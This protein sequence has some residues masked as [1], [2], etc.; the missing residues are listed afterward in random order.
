MLLPVDMTK[1]LILSLYQ[2]PQTIF[3]LK[4]ISLLVPQI[5]YQNLKRRLYYFVKSGKLIRVR[6]G[7]YAKEGY[8]VR[9][10]ANKLYAPSYVSFETVLQEAGLIFQ[11]YETIFLASYVSREIAFGAHRLVYRKIKDEILLNIEGVEEKEGYF[12]ASCERAFLDTVFLYKE[13]HFD[14]LSPLNWDKVGRLEETYH[15]KALKKRAEEYY[16]IY[17]EE[18]VEH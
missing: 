12:I 5:S 17:K 13:Y 10:L 14:N 4:E 6:R 7:I 16:Q 11:N 1:N 18:H 9:E 8:N 2:K 3:T 15:S